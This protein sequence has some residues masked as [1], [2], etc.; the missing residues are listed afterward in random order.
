[1]SAGDRLPV[2]TFG[3]SLLLHLLVMIGMQEW[4]WLQ[5]QPAEAPRATRYVMRFQPPAPTPTPAATPVAV[6][7]TTPIAPAPVAPAVQ[8]QTPTAIAP[9]PVAPPVHLQ[10]PTPIAP[11]P[12]KPLPDLP[13][14][15][16]KPKQPVVKPPVP[17]QRPTRQ[18]PTHTT[19]ATPRTVQP[20]PPQVAAVEPPRQPSTHAK[21]AA[22]SR[23]QPDDVDPDALTAYL[24]RIFAALEQHK[25]YP[26]YAKRRAMNG[27]VVL[28][29]VILPDGRVVNP[30]IA[31][32]EGHKSFRTAALQALSRAGQMPPFPSDIQ[33]SKLMVEVPISY[34]IKER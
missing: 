11:T 17:A 29:F 21:P 31:A 33:R 25:R 14:P 9:T 24:H 6:A 18:A 5:P 2:V 30:K 23:P 12:I 8:P 19:A 4:T 28:Q 13:R 3:L 27:H 26:T 20:V 10:N 32:S 1:M 15:P 22:P 16:S 7:P 34:E